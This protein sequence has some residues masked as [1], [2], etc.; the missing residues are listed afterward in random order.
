MLD[1]N[2]TDSSESST[3]KPRKGRPKKAVLTEGPQDKDSGLKFA[4]PV[5]KAVATKPK[6]T[7]SDEVF[8]FEK[9]IKELDPWFSNN[10]DDA[11]DFTPDPI[12]QVRA[13]R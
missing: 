3:P 6:N 12:F 8:D 5:G 10:P 9:D 2:G 1:E 11:L 13:T 7:M 4:V